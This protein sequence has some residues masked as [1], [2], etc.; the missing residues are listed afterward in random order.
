MPESITIHYQFVFPDGETTAFSLDLDRNDL[1]LA[2]PDGEEPPP[3]TAL[4]NQQCPD[5]P[6]TVVS[7]PQCPIARNLARVVACFDQR[8]SYQS[9][10]VTVVTEARSYHKE[11]TLQ[12]GLSALLGIVM[13]T[14]G[15]PPM[16]QLKPLVRFHL[17]FATLEETTFRTISLHL[18]TQLLRQQRGLP[19]AFDL[20]GLNG[21]YAGVAAVNNHFAKR[22]RTAAQK[23]ANL[24]ALVNL[25]CFTTLV[26]ANA[27]ELLREIE[28]NFP[29]T[30]AASTPGLGRERQD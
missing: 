8:F 9:V 20:D 30:T 17:P 5:C 27:W 10:S 19:A 3:W 28:E 15:C 2:P 24:N 14:S 7:T 6:F 1:R 18:I 4:D 12:E 21:I 13:V 11:T 25:D 29:L 23:D 26:P 16:G 22:L